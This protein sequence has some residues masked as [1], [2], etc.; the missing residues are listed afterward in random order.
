[1]KH[2]PK[3]SKENI[4]RFIPC[5]FWYPV[6]GL[7]E[8]LRKNSNFQ[9]VAREIVK[10]YAIFDENQIQCI[11]DNIASF[12]RGLIIDE[13]LGISIVS[14]D[15]GDGKREQERLRIVDLFIKLNNGGTKLSSF[16]L[17][18]S[19]L[20]GFD[21]T[22]EDFLRET[23]EMY[24]D[25]GLSQENLIRLIF[26]LQDNSRKEMAQVENSD[27]KFATENRERISACL[28]ALKGFLEQSKM[29]EYYKNSNASFISLLFIP[30]GF[31]TPPLCGGL[32]G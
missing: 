3:Q 30:L 13:P 29:L 20:K 10:N 16:D 31:N 15:K 5:H 12:Q 17:V 2:S 27:A 24:S 32:N 23:V 21:A 26:L 4:E 28:K 22:M 6:S 25:I 8:R 18:A 14:I 7:V 19:K 11:N 9:Q 1:L